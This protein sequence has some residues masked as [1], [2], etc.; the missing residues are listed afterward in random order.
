MNQMAIAFQHRTIKSG[1]HYDGKQPDGLPRYVGPDRWI[2][3]PI[4]TRKKHI[5]WSVFD[6]K[7]EHVG[8]VKTVKELP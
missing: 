2:A 7:G 5:G 6:N 3:I 8:T 4:T 1:W